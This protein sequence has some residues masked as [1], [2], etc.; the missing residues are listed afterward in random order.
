M[1]RA[2]LHVH[3]SASDGDD[4]KRVV[5]YAKLRGLDAVAIT[6]HFKPASPKLA[7]RAEGMLI[8]PGVELEYEVGHVLVLGVDER[9]NPPP[10]LPELADECRDCGYVAVLAH[11]AVAILSR[12]GQLER[13]R[14]EARMLDAIETFNSMYPIFGLMVRLSRGLAASLAMPETGGSDAHRASSVG[15]CYTLIDSDPSLDDVLVA[16][17]RGRVTPRGAPSPIAERLRVAVGVLRKAPL[18][19]SRGH[20]YLA[21]PSRYLREQC[22]R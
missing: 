15:R 20:A 1:L 5:A 6:D 2:D 11:P 12:P 21:A 9:F 3:T 8:L 10:T 13:L 22:T 19:I 16:I 17:A 7:E 4:F 14:A 18:K